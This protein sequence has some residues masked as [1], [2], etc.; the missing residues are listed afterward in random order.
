M[1]AG[2]L[3]Q[4][5]TI[6]EKSVTQNDY[7][8]EVVIWV[9]YYT[10]WAA[11]EPVR[12][13]EFYEREMAGAEADTRIVIRWPRSLEIKP[14]MRVKHGSRYYDI[15]AVIRVEERLREIQLM[16]REVISDEWEGG[17]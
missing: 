17:S 12:G 6:Q 13:R 11:V 8:E 10:T 14:E 4:R 7:G 15:V 16:C 5:V 9:D 3:R 1:R 2:R